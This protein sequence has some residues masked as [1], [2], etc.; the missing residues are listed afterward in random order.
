MSATSNY[1]NNKKMYTLKQRERTNVEQKEQLVNLGRVV[2]GCLLNRT[3]VEI[4][5]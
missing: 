1:F 5:K 2:L 4:L 3:C